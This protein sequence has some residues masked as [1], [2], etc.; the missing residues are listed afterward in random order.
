MR[1]ARNVHDNIPVR[2]ARGALSVHAVVRDTT[3]CEGV[4]RWRGRRRDFLTFILGARRFTKVLIHRV[5]L[6]YIL[7]FK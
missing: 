6:L 1:G 4:S 5:R 7:Q 2:S 3:R